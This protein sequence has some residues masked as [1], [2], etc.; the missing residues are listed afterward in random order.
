MGRLPDESVWPI[1]FR[2]IIGFFVGE[3]V[4]VFHGNLPET[5]GFVSIRSQML[6]KYSDP[7]AFFMHASQR[8]SG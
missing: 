8:P 3:S 6:R 7:L 1:E 4:V 5:P 2:G